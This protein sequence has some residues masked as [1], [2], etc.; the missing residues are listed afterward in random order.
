MRVKAFSLACAVVLAGV[1]HGFV[2]FG[3]DAQ[4]LDA[5]PRVEERGKGAEMSGPMFE[6]KQ[7]IDR[8]TEQLRTIG[9]TPA[10]R[11]NVSKLVRSKFN[12][13]VM[14]QGVLGPN[15]HKASQQE[16]ERFVDLFSQLLEETYIGRVREYTGQMI[17]FGVEQIRENRAVVD[18]YIAMDTGNE[19]PIS[20]KMLKNGAEWQVYDVVIEEVSLVRNYRSSYASILRKKNV[21]GLLTEMQAKI[22]ELQQRHA[23]EDRNA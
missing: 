9:S 17:R 14:S 16:R 1:I 22:E 19:I 5:V 10:W 3:A 11:D 20:Y 13:E 15:W 18:T 8:I 23:I 4:E 12:F 6:I 7:T 21:S 2:P